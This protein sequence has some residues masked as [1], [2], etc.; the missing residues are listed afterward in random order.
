MDYTVIKKIPN[1]EAVELAVI[2]NGG[3]CPCKLEQN[4]NTKCMCAEFRSQAIGECSCGLYFKKDADYLLYTKEGCPRCELLK[5]ELKRVN[6]TYVESTDY[7][8]DIS[9]VPVLVTSSGIQYNFKEAM[10]LFPRPRTL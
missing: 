4:E 9:A 3:Y 10:T 7:P 5:K 1:S 6:K 8:D 2:N